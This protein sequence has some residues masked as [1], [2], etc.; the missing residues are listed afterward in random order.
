M[1]SLV[2]RHEVLMDATSICRW[3]PHSEITMIATPRGLDGCHVTRF[4][5]VPSH[6]KGFL[7]TLPI[8][9]LAKLTCQF[10]HHQ[11]HEAA[12]PT[13]VKNDML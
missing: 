2:P 7:G 10:K 12:G 9:R 1:F 3:V 4:R 6:A 8:F 13:L 5:W 11:V